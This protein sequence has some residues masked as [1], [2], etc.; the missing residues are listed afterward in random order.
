MTNQKKYHLFI[1]I[2]TFSRNL[3]ATF[4]L[5]ILYK[6]SN[7]LMAVYFFLLGSALCSFLF[8]YPLVYLSRKLTFKWLIIFSSIALVISYYYLFLLPLSLLNLIIIIVTH[9]L[10]A[11]L[12]WLAN[13]YFGLGILGN[14]N[15]EVGVGKIIIFRQLA[16][17]L[18]SYLGALLLTYLSFYSVLL[19]IIILHIIMVIPLFYLKPIKQQAQLLQKGINKT[20]KEIPSSYLLFL[21]LSQFW[22]L[23]KYLFPLYIYLYIKS[24]FTYIGIFNFLVGLASMF[25]THFLAR[26]MVARQKDYLL[27]TSIL[28]CLVWVLKLNVLGT[29]LF[30]I[31]GLV[32]GLVT[33]MGELVFEKNLYKWGQG[34]DRLSYVF[35]TEGVQ[36]WGRLLIMLIFILLNNLK[37]NLYL[38]AVMF[39]L[40]GFVGLSIKKDCLTTN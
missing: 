37:I 25:F 8:N 12:Y 19:I 2:G 1:F 40:L 18:T 5:I 7:S 27:L 20:I 35:V 3:I 39:L 32:D 4:I 31:V 34:Y 36:S 28:L 21:V 17:I 16:L 11:H 24:K 22:L 13:H 14:S 15:L 30:L 23:G 10:N 29:T 33:K 9:V 26:N 6:K 38:V